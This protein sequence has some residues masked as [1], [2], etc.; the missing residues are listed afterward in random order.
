MLNMLVS[1]LILVADFV[2]IIFQQPWPKLVTSYFSWLG[3]N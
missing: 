1:F 2:E 3:S